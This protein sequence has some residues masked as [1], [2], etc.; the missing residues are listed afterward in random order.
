MFLRSE[1][2]SEM[3]FLQRK[4]V[5]QKEFNLRVIGERKQHSLGV[6]SYKNSCLFSEDVLKKKQ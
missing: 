4:F 1:K 2:Y 5:F 3:K 6:L